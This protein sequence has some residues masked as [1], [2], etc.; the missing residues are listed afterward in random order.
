MPNGQINALKLA[1][2]GH[3][4]GT[5][6]DRIFGVN[7]VSR[8]LREDIDG[9]ANCVVEAVKADPQRKTTCEGLVHV[10]L[11]EK[12][13]E[14]CRYTPDNGVLKLLWL[15]RA[16]DFILRFVDYSLLKGEKIQVAGRTAYSEVLKPYHGMLVKTLVNLAFSLA[17]SRDGFV[18][19]LGFDNINDCVATIEPFV[20]TARP[21]INHV[22]RLLADNGCDFPDKV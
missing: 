9:H 2:A 6:Y 10:T 14:W 7:T 19:A 13:L 16:L 1:E 21:I 15:K 11:Q 22:H 17:P 4:V 12:G 5:L 18:R 8:K 3:L 20:T